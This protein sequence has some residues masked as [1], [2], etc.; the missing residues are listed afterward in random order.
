MAVIRAQTPGLICRHSSH[1]Q[2]QQ[3]Q[4]LSLQERRSPEL[5]ASRMDFQRE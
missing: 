4:M 1:R 2:E 3:R 5:R